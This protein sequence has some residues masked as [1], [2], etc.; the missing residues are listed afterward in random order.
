MNK[1]SNLSD[2]VCPIFSGAGKFCL[3][4]GLRQLTQDTQCD[5]SCLQTLL[6]RRNAKLRLT[7]GVGRYFSNNK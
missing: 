3:D 6:T 7:F 4:P 5:V 1:F 2:S